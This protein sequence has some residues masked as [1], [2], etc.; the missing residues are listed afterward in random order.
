MKTTPVVLAIVLLACFAAD[1]DEATDA[2][3][4]AVAV[5][6]LPATPGATVTES[7]VSEPSRVPGIPQDIFARKVE[8]HV[9][10]ESRVAIYVF[11][12]STEP[13]KESVLRWIGI[14]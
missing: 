3:C 2:S 9:R 11:I 6:R 5:S 13:G 4:V 8:I 12:C 14:W 10:S 1:A 7:R